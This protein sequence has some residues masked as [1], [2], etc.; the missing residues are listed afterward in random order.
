LSRSPAAVSFFSSV[1]IF[2]M[3]CM[4]KSALLVVAEAE[5]GR[6]RCL[7][8]ESK[9]DWTSLATG[10]AVPLY[11]LVASLLLVPFLVAK[12]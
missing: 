6:G 1:I 10:T 4:D 11:I 7:I 9:G 12:C 5:D 8:K 2:I 3:D